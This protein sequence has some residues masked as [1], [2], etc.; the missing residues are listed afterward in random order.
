[1]AS[2]VTNRGKVIL[3]TN[4]WAGTS[5]RVALVTASYTPSADHNFVADLTNELSGG[6]Y[7]RQTLA[8]LTVTENDTDD[9]A[10]LDAADTVFSS[11]QL[12][13]G[14][15]R[16]AVVYRNVTNDADSPIIAAI[17]L[18]DPPTA[19]TGADFTVAWDATGIIRLT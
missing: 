6:N 4:G 16:Y 7:A 18:G 17:D 11:L 8:S 5:Y 3:V 15:P 9:R 12:A 19:P 14:T 10:Q 13:A 1:M 2:L